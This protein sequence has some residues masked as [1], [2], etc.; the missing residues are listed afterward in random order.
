MSFLLHWEHNSG[1]DARLNKSTSKMKRESS[2]FCILISRPTTCLREKK[3]Y[4]DTKYVWMS[5][6]PL[7]HDCLITDYS[8]TEIWRKFPAANICNY[9]FSQLDGT[10]SST[11][12]PYWHFVWLGVS[13]VC[14]QCYTCG[15]ICAPAVLCPECVVS[16]IFT[17][18]PSYISACSLVCN[19][20]GRDSVVYR[21]HIGLRLLRL[22]IL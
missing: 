4:C 10:L 12:F 7:V 18:A 20:F 17:T 5:D 11:L 3:T 1:G 13:V 14:A 8:F 16:L 9:L 2:P 22:L 19:A 21:F 6:V 15:F